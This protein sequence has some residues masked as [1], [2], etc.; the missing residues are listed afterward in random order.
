MKKW[1]K[2][3]W[4]E[5]IGD[6]VEKHD[7]RQ[8]N[9][10]GQFVVA[11][12][13]MVGDIGQT[14]WQELLGNA[15]TFSVKYDTT[16]VMHNENGYGIDMSLSAEANDIRVDQVDE[17]IG[18]FGE[19]IGIGQY[20]TFTHSDPDTTCNIP[21]PFEFNVIIS[22][23]DPC[24][25]KTVDIAIDR[26]GAEHDLI[27]YDDGDGRVEMPWDGVFNG[28]FIAA[29]YSRYNESSGFVTFNTELKNGSEI[30]AKIELSQTE[31]EKNPGD[32]P[33]IITTNI[34]LHHTPKG[35]VY[36]K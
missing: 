32:R 9:H 8:A 29:N 30:A 16:Y 7:Y 18:L 34:T 4:N 33:G 22:N 35:E 21:A 14:N 27:I 28:W 5:L 2:E 20:N 13:L 25:S 3:V 1:A 26:F 31:N 12:S 6:V 11:A 23:I 17:T 15:M 10:L 24:G 36:I 19:S